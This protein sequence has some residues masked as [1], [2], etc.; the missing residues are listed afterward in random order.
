MPENY[1]EGL[2]TYM[3]FLSLLPRLIL[4]HIESGLPSESLVSF[5]NS[6]IQKLLADKSPTH[7]QHD[8][9]TKDVLKAQNCLDLVIKP[10]NKGSGIVV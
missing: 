8:N 1:D 6:D 4:T 2:T 5:V 9:L 7:H 10:A 3:G